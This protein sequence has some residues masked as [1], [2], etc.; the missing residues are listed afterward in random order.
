MLVQATVQNAQAFPEDDADN[1]CDPVV[2]IGAAVEAGLDE[3]NGAAEGRGA[4][5]DRQ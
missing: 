3:F 5:E 2:D 1:V 4:D